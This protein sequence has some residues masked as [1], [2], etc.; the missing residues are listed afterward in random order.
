M[1]VSTFS[2][3]FELEDELEDELVDLKSTWNR[4]LAIMDEPNMHL[5][6]YFRSKLAIILK[7]CCCF[8]VFL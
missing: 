6:Y 1:Q 4:L 5:H 2:H 3:L 7:K 8:L